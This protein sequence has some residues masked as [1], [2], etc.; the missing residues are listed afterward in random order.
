MRKNH[1]TLKS[2]RLKSSRR[3]RNLVGLSQVKTVSDPL[4]PPSIVLAS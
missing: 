3:L 4:N 1:Q 2:L